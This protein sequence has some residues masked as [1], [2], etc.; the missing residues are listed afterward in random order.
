MRLVRSQIKRLYCHLFYLSNVVKWVTH[1]FTTAAAAVFSLWFPI[2][3]KQKQP[4]PA[5]VDE[6]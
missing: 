6:Y 3:L 2:L 5:P 4:F 1:T